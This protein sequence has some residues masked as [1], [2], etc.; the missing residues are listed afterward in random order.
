MN[1]DLIT[2]AEQKKRAM[3]ILPLVN[4]RARYLKLRG[5]FQ[6]SRYSNDLSLEAENEMIKH[7]GKGCGNW[8]LFMFGKNKRLNQRFIASYQV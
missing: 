3:D 5:R 7:R 6:R 1:L 2:H 4:I 8:P